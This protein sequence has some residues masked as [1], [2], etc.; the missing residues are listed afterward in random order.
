M[1]VPD[2]KTANYESLKKLNIVILS[3]KNQA[4]L[5]IISKMFSTKVF[6]KFV[7]KFD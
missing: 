1:C 3:I 5:L 4:V 6:C 2:L 7:Y